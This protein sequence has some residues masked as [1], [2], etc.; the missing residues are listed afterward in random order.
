ME[1]LKTKAVLSF[2]PALAF[3]VLLFGGYLMNREKPPIP[4][5]TVTADGRTLFTG[6]DVVDG[7]S[8][9]Y[10]RGGQHMGKSPKEAAAFTQA[11]LASASANRSPWCS[12]SSACPNSRA[13]GA[14]PGSGGAPAPALRRVQRCDP[15]ARSSARP[16]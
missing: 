5:A 2:M 8:Y 14:A 15:G 3:G 10:G 9:F 16:V 11:D 13:A 6:K 4:R 7:Q 12:T 1:S